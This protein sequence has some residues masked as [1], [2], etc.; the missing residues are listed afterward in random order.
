MSSMLCVDLIPEFW[1]E[2]NLLLLFLQL[3]TCLM[4]TYFVSTVKKTAMNS[5]DSLAFLELVIDE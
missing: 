5:I 4:R 3:F 1:D 2:N